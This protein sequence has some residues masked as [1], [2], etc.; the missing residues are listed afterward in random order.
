MPQGGKIVEQASERDQGMVGVH[1]YG[2]GGWREGGD[3]IRRPR[4]I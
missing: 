1:T 4:D 2:M 3:C